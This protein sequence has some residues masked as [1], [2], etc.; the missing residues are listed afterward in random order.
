MLLSF[1]EFAIVNKLFCQSL[2]TAQQGESNELPA[3]AFL[4]LSSYILHHAFR[5]NR[6]GM[7]GHLSLIILR[8]V[9][10][11]NGMCKMLCGDG[12]MSTVRLCRQ[13]QPFLPP[14]QSRRTV[15]SH[16]LDIAIDAINHNLR[17]RLDVP[18][19]VSS[20]NMAHR[21][22]CC[23]AHA[24]IQL[25]YHWQF[26]WQSL[27]SLIRFLVTYENDMKTINTDMML[28]V[29]PLLKL[30]ALTIVAGTSFLTPPAYDDLIYKL[31]ESSKVLTRFKTTYG[32]LM[33]SMVSQPSH[34]SASPID[35]LIR[36]TIHYNEL[37]ERENAKGRAGKNLLPSQ[38]NRI[39]RQGFESLELPSLEGGLD[40]WEPWQEG[41]ERAIIKRVGR[42]AVEDV[43][44]LVR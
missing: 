22:L 44:N 27:L 14:D 1:Y 10:E 29:S 40:V 23:L 7:Y 16:L 19:Y 9:I 13:R 30:F 38:V 8:I 15:G 31:V 36:V 39:I 28:L 3:N 34:A 24:R 2:F 32:S 35:I 5:S 43:R 21:I 11:D 26:F 42:M 6:A 20:L 25:K 41:E 33:S 12:S 18:L 4:S 17:R 37:L